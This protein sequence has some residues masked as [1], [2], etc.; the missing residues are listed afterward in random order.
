M[1][2]HEQQNKIS[3]KNADIHIN[4]TQLLWMGVQHVSHLL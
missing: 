3:P 4:N 2:I 1:T